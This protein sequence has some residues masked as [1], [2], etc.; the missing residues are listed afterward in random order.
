MEP[1]IKAGTYRYATE[2]SAIVLAWA[3][4]DGAGIRSQCRIDGAP[5]LVRHAAGITGCITPVSLSGQAMWAAWN[6]GFDRA[7]WNYSTLEFPEL[8]PRHII[9]AMAQAHRR[10]AAAGSGSG[11]QGLA[12]AASSVKTG[13]ELIKLFC[14]PD[15]DRDAGKPCQ[16]IGRRSCATPSPTSS[17][18]ATCVRRTRQLTRAEWDE[19]WAMEAINERGVAIDLAMVAHAADARRARTP[20]TRPH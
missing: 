10:R 6:A 16:A 18:C 7:V 3:I 5:A 11:R 15:L 13:K 2:A 9:D 12:L 20:R 14:V 4:G 19:Y 1:P 8:E 17:P